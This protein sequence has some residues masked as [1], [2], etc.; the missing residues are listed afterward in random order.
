MRTALSKVTESVTVERD[1]RGYHNNHKTA[2]EREEVVINHIKQFKTIESHY[3][4]KNVRHG[5][6]P[7][8]LSVNVMHHMYIDW[9]EKQDLNPENY[10]FYKREFKERFNLA[11]QKPKKDVCDKCK[12]FKN[13]AD[14]LKTEE[15]IEQ[16]KIHRNKKERACE[17]KQA[18]KD[19]SKAN[20]NVLA[21]AFD[22]EKVLRTITGKDTQYKLFWIGNQEGNGGVGVMLAEK[23]I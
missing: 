16:N 19:E 4:R 5:Y 7:Q 15:V 6:L 21:A 3:V 17:Y 1:K 8:E 12:E 11:F 22:L 20:E 14:N 13:I 9:C 18:K 2:K 23:W 10:D